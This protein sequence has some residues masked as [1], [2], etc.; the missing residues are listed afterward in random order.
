MLCY[1]DAM[2]TLVAILIILTVD[3]NAVS[4][5]KK[6]QSERPTILKKVTIIINFL[7]IFVLS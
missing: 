3:L 1:C 5:Y 2:V 6:K 4:D 7:K